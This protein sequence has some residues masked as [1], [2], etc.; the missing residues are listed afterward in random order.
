MHPNLL[1]PPL[2]EPHVLLL[3]FERLHQAAAKLLRGLRKFEQSQCHQLQG[4]QLVVGKKVQDQPALFFAVE[5]AH[6]A[7]AELFPVVPL[8]QPQAGRTTRRTRGRNPR[9]G[10]AVL[11]AVE[12]DQL[13]FPARAEEHSLG[14]LANFHEG[15]IMH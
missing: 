5:V 15:N 10:R 4:E 14:E 12:D 3:V 1:H 11:V 2:V 8:V 7:E 6:V 13:V 9:T